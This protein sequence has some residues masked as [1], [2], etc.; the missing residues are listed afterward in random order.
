MNYRVSGRFFG[1]RQNIHES[2]A[3]M[4]GETSQSTKFSFAVMVYKHT[5]RER[6]DTEKKLG[7]AVHCEIS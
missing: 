5:A 6:G 7:K 4:T 2:Y 3:N 1:S